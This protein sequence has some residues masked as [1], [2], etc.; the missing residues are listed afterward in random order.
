MRPDRFLRGGDHTPFL[1]NGFIAVRFTEF[2]E[3]YT[4]Q[5]Q[6]IREEDGIEYGDKVKFVD[7]EYAA[8]V[9]KMN[10]A[11]MVSLAKAP[12]KP[13]RVALQVDLS[14]I[15]KLSWEAPAG[16]PKPKGYNVLIRETYQPFW[17]EKI[18]AEDTEA[19]LP[20]SKDNYFFAVQSVGDQGHLSQIVIPEPRR[21]Q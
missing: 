16:G 21:R 15:T 18:Y 12:A 2:N 10:L 9:A 8:N 13:Q 19:E 20:Y 17:E 14:N 1:Q 3:N 11:T 4:Q 7:F 6:N 5:H